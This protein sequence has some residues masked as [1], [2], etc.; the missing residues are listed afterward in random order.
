[1]SRIKYILAAFF[2]FWVFLAPNAG[3]LGIAS[4]YLE[5]NT[6]TLIEGSSADYGIRIQNPENKEIN[7]AVEFD[8][9]F[10]S[11]KEGQPEYPIPP[12]SGRS[13]KFEVGATGMEEGMYDAGYAVYQTGAGISLKLA[14]SIKIKVIEDPQE[15]I[16][17]RSR[18]YYAL[19]IS[20]ASIFVGIVLLKRNK[21]TYEKAAFY[22]G[23]AF[24]ISMLLFGIISLIGYF[25]LTGKIL[26]AVLLFPLWLAFKPTKFL[27][28]FDKKWLDHTIL[29][30]FYVFV[31]DT[32]TRI[33]QTTKYNPVTL[34]KID[35]Y[36]SALP[37]P[38]YRFI[39]DSSIWVYNS[40]PAISLFSANAGFVVLIILAVLISLTQKYDK[41]SMMY[42]LTGLF[43]R[44]EEF[45]DKFAGKG[46]HKYTF[47]KI[48]MSL[49]ALLLFSHY[50]FNLVN[51]WFIV[52]I[53]NS[54]FIIAFFL[55]IKDLKNTG[56]KILDR[57]GGFDEELIL[58]AKRVFH[59]QKYFI[60]GF[61]VLLVFHFMSDATLFLVPYFIPSVNLDEYYVSVL[62]QGP[63]LSLK[64]LF[65]AEYISNPVEKVYY[66]IT[67]IVSSL[68]L[69]FLFMLPI[70]L[71][72]LLVLRRH[73]REHLEKRHNRVFLYVICIA[74]TVFLLAPWTEALPIIKDSAGN[75]VNVQGVDFITT[76]ISDSGY[77]LIFVFTAMI[78]LSGIAVLF[79]GS[80]RLQEYAI[81]LTF[82]YSLAFLG[83][84]V[85]NFY[86]STAVYYFNLIKFSA[87]SE[88]FLL[89]VLFLALIIIETLFYL[90][91][92]IVF[93]YY[94]SRYLITQETKDIMSEKAIFTYTALFFLVPSILLYSETGHAITTT[95]IAIVSLLIFSFALYKE[96]KWQEHR[97][98]Y[99]LGVSIVISI[100]QILFIMSFWAKNLSVISLLYIFM[101]SQPS[102]IL[103]V[104]YAALLLFR[105][106][107][108]F[109]P[110][111]YGHLLKCAAFGV[112]FG[113][114]FYLVTEPS[115]SQL[116]LPISLL[117]IYLALVAIA[118]EV[119]FR[120][121]LL[122][123][124]E[125]AFSFEVAV[126]LQALVF[127]SAHFVGIKAVFAHYSGIASAANTTALYAAVYFVMLYSFAV[128]SS[129]LYGRENKNITYPIVFHLVTNFSVFLLG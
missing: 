44:K 96:F 4:D 120:G 20:A 126:L 57:M 26:G 88:N 23:W 123:L 64:L 15:A 112:V 102:I 124:A 71:L 35:F 10:F 115:M 46:R 68:G 62:N 7:V 94:V 121:I 118:E 106:K 79:F 113:S 45:W 77:S 92:F 63:H 101:F 80:R 83:R 86:I 2:A 39:I 67:Y 25:D 119:L 38:A 54:T 14:N 103:A 70:I 40:G 3:A 85:W 50:F 74:S 24:K 42:P 111:E 65:D 43:F 100:F 128:V 47:I 19:I 110:L 127:A 21:K 76:R 41:G 5:D 60:L 13:I 98:D 30:S 52:T 8:R 69:L 81:T 29:A 93:G 17:K 22:A 11:L 91:G 51:Q 37:E 36:L 9:R 87:N 82:L 33:I 78:V 27:F 59:D 18:F 6:I 55:S 117:F 84:Y 56:V 125:R 97:D 73:L 28:G 32:F 90:G 16:K 66:F 105:I 48:I 114:F 129:F 108:R 116:G 61:S 104:S 89:I 31:L 12:K 107:L 58:V 34:S 72:F 53:G 1:M 49:A 95:T 99:I 75:Y 122:K 109:A